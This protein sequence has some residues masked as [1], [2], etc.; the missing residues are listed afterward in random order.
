MILNGDSP[1]AGHGPAPAPGAGSGILFAACMALAVFAAVAMPFIGI[2]ANRTASGTGMPL[3]SVSAAWF[4]AIALVLACAA[5]AR[6]AVRGSSAPSRVRTAL[7]AVPVACLVP[8]ALT[9]LAS[10]SARTA[11]TLPDRARVSV[12]SGF[13]I[14]MAAAYGMSVAETREDAAQGTNVSAATLVAAGFVAIVLAA[15]GAFGRL[16]I[17]R[18]LVSRREVFAGESLRH[19]LYALGSVTAALAVGIPLGYMA[20]R[21]RRWERPVFFVANMAQAVPTLSLL[22]LLIVPLSILG[23][24][25]PLFDALGVRGVGW[26][27]ASIALF[28]YALLPVAANAHAGFRMTEGPVLDAARGL[29]MDTRSR[30]LRIELPLAL[31]AIIDGARTALTQNMGNAVLAGLVGG[32]GLGSLLFL[33]LAQAAPDLILLA[34]L[35]IVAMA[36]AA[37][38]L[39]HLAGR[40]ARRSAG[41]EGA[42]T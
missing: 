24:R 8:V 5:A 30:F 42:P 7:A 38:R 29:G 37:D 15:A 32:G 18:E 13:W 20:A 36:L 4:S 23:R 16:S 19:F 35:P 34:A 11:S 6:L 25:I 22:G 1:G 2:R 33:G 12:G 17:A 39:M 9:A 3:L 27:P 28:L 41:P 10:V 14:L 31:P 21:S 26:A 40:A